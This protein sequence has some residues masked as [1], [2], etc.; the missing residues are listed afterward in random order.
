[1]CSVGKS[2]GVVVVDGGG[3]VIGVTNGVCRDV[4]RRIKVALPQ[5]HSRGGQSAARFGRLADEARH[6]F[7]QRVVE[8]VSS[9][10]PLST[11][12][13]ADTGTEVTGLVVVGAAEMK[14]IRYGELS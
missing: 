12:T 5:K 9:S 10:F 6:V 7:V 14:V 11:G 1:M 8:S 4:L 13:A 3:C 2:V